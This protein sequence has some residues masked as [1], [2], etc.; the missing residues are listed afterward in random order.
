MSY[1]SVNE[2]AKEYNLKDKNKLETQ[3]Y[4]YELWKTGDKSRNIKRASS[5]ILAKTAFGKSVIGLLALK[6]NQLK[7]RKGVVIVPTKALKKDWEDHKKWWNL[8]YDV[9]VINTAVK[10]MP[11]IKAELVV[12]DEVHLFGRGPLWKKI[13]SLKSPF[14][15]GLTATLPEDDEKYFYLLS[16][17]PVIAEITWDEVLN[18]N[19]ICD[20]QIY[21]YPIYVTPQ[22]AYRLDKWRNDFWKYVNVVGDFKI[23]TKVLKDKDYRKELAYSKNIDEGSLFGSA[24]T[25][26]TIVSKRAEFFYNHQLKLDRCIDIVNAFPDKNIITFNQR[27]E[28]VD[29]LTF[30]IGSNAA[31]YHSGH[32]DNHNDWVLRSFKH[33]NGKIKVI[34][35]AMALNQGVNIPKIDMAIFNSW[36]S[37]PTSFNQR[38]GRTTRLAKNKDIA[39]IFINPLSR[40]DGKK[41]QDERWLEKAMTDVPQSKVKIINSLDYEI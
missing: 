21:K 40:K 25:V 24:K 36:T 41:T 16:K 1:F 13:F 20:F 6:E 12:F 26:I 33:H 18:K 37:S 8:E 30:A 34:N 4:L 29:Q 38:L 31:S 27:N 22:E 35:T 17:L 19:Y 15:L 39:T 32:G 9:I 10:K 14:Q 11:E 28:F 3:I 23:A 5:I 2:I 7:G